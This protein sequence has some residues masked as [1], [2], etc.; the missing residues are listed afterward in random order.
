MKNQKKVTD[1]WGLEL[2]VIVSSHIC[3]GNQTQVLI[4]TEPAQQPKRVGL[5]IGQEAASESL[6]MRKEEKERLW[7][8]R[9]TNSADKGPSYPSVNRA[10]S[11]PHDAFL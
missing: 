7:I 9:K 4:T 2:Q 10:T 3:V 1:P 11:R 6:L 5:G 8:C